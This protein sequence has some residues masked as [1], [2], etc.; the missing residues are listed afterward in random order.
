MHRLFALCATLI[1]AATQL[2]AE[3]GDHGLHKAPWMRDMF[4][5]LSEDLA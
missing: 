3:V 5:D 2:V 4:K 1:L